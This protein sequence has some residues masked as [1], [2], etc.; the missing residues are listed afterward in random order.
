MT[1][2][3]C[4]PAGRRYPPLRS[5]GCGPWSAIL[6]TGGRTPRRH[7]SGRSPARRAGAGRANRCGRQCSTRAAGR[8]PRCRAS[9]ARRPRTPGG[10]IP[11]RPEPRQ[12]R[13][14]GGWE[15]SEI[16][17][18]QNGF[19]GQIYEKRATEGEKLLSLPCV[20][21]LRRVRALPP[22]SIQEAFKK[23]KEPFR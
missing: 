12:R 14:T 15:G 19:S 3:R 2:S 7:T 18:V 21:R 16:S 11:P 8:R 4:R 22:K 10:R 13:S 5:A 1:R 17:S 23:H 6:R 20:E 9:A